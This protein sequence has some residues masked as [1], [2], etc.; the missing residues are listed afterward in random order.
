MK[1]SNLHSRMKRYEASSKALLMRRT[2]A[3]IRVDGKA[4]HTFTKDMEAPFDERFRNA[5]QQT[6]L[7]M[8]QNIQGCVFGYTQSDE[9]SLVLTDYETITTDAWYDYNVQKMTSIAASM[10]TLYFAEALRA[11]VD[12]YAIRL[13]AEQP[14]PLSQFATK[15]SNHQSGGIQGNNEYISCMR[16]KMFA[17]L[18]DARA[19]SVPKEEVCNCM[20][21][22]QQDATR[23]SIQS[24][25]QYYFSQSQLNRKSLSQIQEMLWTEAHVNWNDIRTEWKRGAC[26]YRDN[27][28]SSKAHFPWI[29]DKAPPVFTQNRNYIERWI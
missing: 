15:R 19:F 25:G 13:T 1:E 29:I 17:A 11:E 8:C 6:M 12:A 4:F 2:P 9:I 7:K 23:N 24:V 26:C 5:M 3:I 28:D 14:A 20:I 21:W 16:A 27:T 22:R 10:A 18:F